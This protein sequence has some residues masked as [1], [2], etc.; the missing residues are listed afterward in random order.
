MTRH[1]T[2]IIGFVHQVTSVYYSTH[3]FKMPLLVDTE[4]QVGASEHGIRFSIAHVALPL[5]YA[6]SC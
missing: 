1:S 2:E 3:D 6:M 4:G 5:S